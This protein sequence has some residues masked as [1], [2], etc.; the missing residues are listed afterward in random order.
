MKPEPQTLAQS[1]LGQETEGSTK[2]GRAAALWQAL[3]LEYQPH[4]ADF[5]AQFYA[6]I[7][8]I[9]IDQY[10]KDITKYAKAWRQLANEIDIHEW[11]LP[12]AFLAQRFINGL[13][14]YA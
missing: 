13:R 1:K 8:S 5:Q 11:I 2:M 12:D 14:N 4:W 10:E 7:A 6:K 9:S 3:E